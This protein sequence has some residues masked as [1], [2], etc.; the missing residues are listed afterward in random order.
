M[1]FIYELPAHIFELFLRSLLAEHL[2]R[3]CH[4]P[5]NRHVALPTDSCNCERA[6]L[7]RS[8][9]HFFTEGSVNNE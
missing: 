6:L 1:N 8:S 5:A 9:V 4:A 7:L 2:K 3:F